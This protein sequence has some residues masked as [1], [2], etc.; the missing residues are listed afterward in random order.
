MKPQYVPALSRYCSTATFMI[1]LILSACMAA[2][3]T[4]P[5]LDNGFKPYGSYDGSNL[6]SISLMDGN[7]LLHAPVETDVPQR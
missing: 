1:V 4:Q 6:D 3:Q 2:A 7:F 5:G